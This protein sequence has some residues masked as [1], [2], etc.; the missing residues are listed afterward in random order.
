MTG[1]EPHAPR[2]TAG[3]GP[4]WDRGHFLLS[5]FGGGKFGPR[6]A[7]LHCDP[8]NGLAAGGAE[9][10]MRRRVAPAARARPMIPVQRQL[11]PTTGGAASYSAL[12]LPRS[13][14]GPWPAV[15]R[16]AARACGSVTCLGAGHPEMDRSHGVS[17]WQSGTAHGS[18]ELVRAHTPRRGRP[19]C[20]NTPPGGLVGAAPWSRSGTGP[21]PLRTRRVSYG[22]VLE[23]S[24]IQPTWES[25]E[26][27][28]PEASGPRRRP[29]EFLV[30]LQA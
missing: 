4:D 3:R 16:G 30:R 17:G 12:Q 24:C 27:L 9:M 6:S 22:E 10:R 20:R 29:T 21:L 13:R 14:L 1:T 28:Q 19:S 25:G 23:I 11:Q 5:S 7:R 8:K 2:G 18:S 15:P 26:V